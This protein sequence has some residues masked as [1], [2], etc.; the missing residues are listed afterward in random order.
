[1]KGRKKFKNILHL[2]INSKGSKDVLQEMQF[3]Q[4]SQGFLVQEEQGKSWGIR[5][6]KIR[7]Q[8]GRCWRLDKTYL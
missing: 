6:K 7:C 4:N 1:M 5:K 2:G 3:T 8:I